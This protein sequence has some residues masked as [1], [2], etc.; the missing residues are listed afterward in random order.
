MTPI[1]IGIL[2]LSLAFLQ[3]SPSPQTL[4]P[5]CPVK[6][7]TPLRRITNGDLRI[8]KLIGAPKLEIPA[9]AKAAHIRGIVSIEAEIDK[10]GRVAALRRPE[11]HP[12]LINAAMDAAKQYR[13]EPATVQCKPI[14]MWLVIEVEFKTEFDPVPVQ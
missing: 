10:E 5:G 6:P 4:P 8:P 7:G 9:L 3:A 14:S 2:A 12:L 1:A 11:G 13:Y